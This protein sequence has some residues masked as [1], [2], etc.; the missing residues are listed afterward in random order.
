[1]LNQTTSLEYYNK[2]SIKDPTKIKISKIHGI[3]LP[4]NMLY[5]EWG[6]VLYHHNGLIVLNYPIK[7]EDFYISAKNIGPEE[8]E[9]IVTKDRMELLTFRDKYHNDKYFTRIVNNNTYHFVNNESII[10]ST[11]N[12]KIKHFIL[13]S[14]N[15]YYKNNYKDGLL[16]IYIIIN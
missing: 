15:F 6:K 9:V 12:K 1:M 4:N 16:F 10:V 11:L 13:P 7:N 5:L 8:W 3:D 14:V 2:I